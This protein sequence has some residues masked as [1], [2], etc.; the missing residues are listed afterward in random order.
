MKLNP[1]ISKAMETVIPAAQLVSE[2]IDSPEDYT[3]QEA[4]GAMESLEIAVEESSRYHKV[5]MVD[6]D[7]ALELQ[8]NFTLNTARQ[9]IEGA[10]Y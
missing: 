5:S 9:S 2:V 6:L 10:E 8:H 7:E 1:N 3:K 4:L